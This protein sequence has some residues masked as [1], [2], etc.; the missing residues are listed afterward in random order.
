MFT[1]EH[2]TPPQWQAGRSDAFLAAFAVAR[3]ANISRSE[4]EMQAVISD[5]RFGQL[6]ECIR[7]ETVGPWCLLPSQRPRPRLRW[8]SQYI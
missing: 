7:C 4:G 3:L 8:H 2:L 6:I 5:R 1:V